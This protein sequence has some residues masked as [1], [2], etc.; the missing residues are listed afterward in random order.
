MNANTTAAI[1][2]C[3]PEQ[4]K[5]QML[6]NLAGLEKMHGKA[7]STGKKVRGYTADMLADMIAKLRKGWD[8]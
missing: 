8:L 3:T 1:F 5:V 7:L 4:A 6:R 2:G